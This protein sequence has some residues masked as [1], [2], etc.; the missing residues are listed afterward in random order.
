VK[1]LLDE[2]F[3][4]SL[5][6]ALRAKAIEADHIITLGCR[7]ISDSRI[8]ARLRE[9]SL[10]FL[11]QDADFL[12]PVP[13]CTAVIVVSRVRQSRPIA[14]RVAVWCTA[15]RDLIHTPRPERVFEL[16]DE[17]RLIPATPVDC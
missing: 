4:L 1:V 5:L 3:P 17:G 6:H 15:V 9:E 8:Q 2:N 12:A 11:T 7:G 10:L 16:S 13:Q 14:D